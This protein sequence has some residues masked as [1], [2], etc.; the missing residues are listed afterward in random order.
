M[1]INSILDY[2]KIDGK[3]Y[4]LERQ[5]NQSVNKQKCIE[6]SQVA[7][8]SQLKSSKLE[9]Q[10]TQIA[11]DI[12]NL[13]SVADQNKAKIKQILSQDV[14]KMTEEQIK[15]SIELKDKLVQNLNILDKK[16][17]KLAEMAN[18]VL[19]EFN[20]T[21]TLY[22]NA[23]E[24]YKEFK[25]S[26]DKEAQ[27]INPKIDEL[28]AELVKL[29]KDIDKKL[30]EDYKKRRSDRIFPVFVPLSNKS[31]GGCH[32]EVPMSSISKLEK[33][34]VLVCENCRRIIYK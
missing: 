10:A 8:D 22:K 27:E 6:L 25:E 13:F 12:Q 33:E 21:K 23:G 19:A 17:T 24:K 20:K 4:Q 3:I 31:C 26:Y 9:Q 30:L 7:K 18:A 32:M 29:E 34:G 5:L 2:Q 28:K 15:N 14:E 16:A 1:E 11:N